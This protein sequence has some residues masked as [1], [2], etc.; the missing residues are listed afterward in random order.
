MKSLFSYAGCET[1]A[2]RAAGDCRELSCRMSCDFGFKE[3]IYGCPHCECRQDPCLVSKVTE[4]RI[5]GFTSTRY[6]SAVADI[7]PM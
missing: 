2:C 1:C 3:D 4:S 5:S 6:R 7:E